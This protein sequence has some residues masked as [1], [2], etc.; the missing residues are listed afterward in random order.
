MSVSVDATA[1]K[2]GLKIPSD[3]GNND[4]RR[5]IFRTPGSFWRQGQGLCDYSRKFPGE[6]ASNKNGVIEISDQ[7][8]YNDMHS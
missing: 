8:G 4:Y 6:G 2:N 3:C 1:V 5:S 7:P